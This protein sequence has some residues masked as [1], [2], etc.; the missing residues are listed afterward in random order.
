MFRKLK[1]KIADEVKANPRLQVMFC[2]IWNENKQMIL[3]IFP[4][5]DTRLG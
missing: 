3:F 1:D 2:V 5:G 4:A